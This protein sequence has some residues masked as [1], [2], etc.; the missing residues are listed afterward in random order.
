M[1]P[2]KQP[3]SLFKLCVKNSISII[4]SAIYT[5]EM[6]YPENKYNECDIEALSLRSYLMSLLPARYFMDYLPS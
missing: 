3:N 2:R 4:N 1:S 6:K 5:I